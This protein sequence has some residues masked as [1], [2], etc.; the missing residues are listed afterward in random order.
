MK[1]A[2][3]LLAI[4]SNR[5][6]ARRDSTMMTDATGTAEMTEA[7]GTAATALIETLTRDLIEI[8]TPEDT[9][10]IGVTE[11][12]TATGT[13]GPIGMTE[14]TDATIGGIETVERTT[15]AA[16]A[17][18]NT[19]AKTTDHTSPRTWLPIS[20]CRPSRQ[21]TPGETLKPSRT[22]SVM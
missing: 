5:Q 1:A 21:K 15:E 9:V 20:T 16:I 11:M 8:E 13:T 4:T 3:V 17:G 12:S 7:A 6:V 14:T 22:A 10:M 19:I 18:T 2:E